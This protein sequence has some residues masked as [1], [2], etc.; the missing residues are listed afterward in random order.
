MLFG[1][2]DHAVIEGLGVDDGSNS[3]TDVAAVV[4]DNVTVTGANADSGGTGGVCGT[5]HAFAAGSQDQVDFLHQQSGHIQGGLFDP[6]DDVLGQACCFSCFLHDL[7][8]A[9]GAVLSLGMRADDDSVSG[10]QG[11]QDLEDGGGGGVGGRNDT[12][13]NT[14]GS[15]N[16]LGAEGLVFFDDVTSLSM[17]HMVPNV[18]CSVVVLG[19]LINYDTSLG[20]FVC[21]LCQRNTHLVSCHCCCFADCV[22]LFL[23]E[24][25]P[26]FFSCSDLNQLGFQS[27]YR[28]NLVKLFICHNDPFL[29]IT[30][31]GLGIKNPVSETNAQPSQTALTPSVTS[32]SIRISFATY[33]TGF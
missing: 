4:D 15:G 22:N 33:I 31:V 9:D 14:D 26:D 1:S 11:D 30:V 20:F 6:G 10:L 18:F 3:G 25:S 19:D 23:R 7:S 8:C 13:D 29:K 12:A 27:F 16:A 21:H 28:I 5:D 17:T 2:A 32:S 24:G